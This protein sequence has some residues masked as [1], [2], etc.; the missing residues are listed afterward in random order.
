[1]AQKKAIKVELA[2][3]DD[4]TK[5]I[6]DTFK[7]GTQL[8]LLHLDY[9]NMREQIIKKHTDLNNAIEKAFLAYT[10]LQKK[11]NELGVEP[12][13]QI[14]KLYKEMLNMS[15]EELGR[16]KVLQSTKSTIL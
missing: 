10:D 11:S 4:V 9:N 2:L 5:V 16:Q 15:K 13:P 7:I 6:N 12:S 14:V 1:M 3:V 8:D